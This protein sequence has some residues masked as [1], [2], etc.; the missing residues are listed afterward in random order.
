MFPELHQMFC[1]IKKNLSLIT[2]QIFFEM[3]NIFPKTKHK[4]FP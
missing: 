4:I 2:H 1:E 3:N